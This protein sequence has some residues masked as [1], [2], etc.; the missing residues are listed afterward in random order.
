MARCR[1]RRPDLDRIEKLTWTLIQYKAYEDNRSGIEY[2]LIY[3][4]YEESPPVNRIRADGNPRLQIRKSRLARQHRI[5]PDGNP[6]LPNQPPIDD[7]VVPNFIEDD[8]LKSCLRRG[9][10]AFRPY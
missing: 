8:R 7:D 10:F 9:R 5:Q 3:N 2:S 6:I 4:Y 1:T